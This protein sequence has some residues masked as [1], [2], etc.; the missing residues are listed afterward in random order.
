MGYGYRS[1]RPEWKKD[2]A[3]EAEF[4]AKGVEITLF[5]GD[6]WHYSKFRLTFE[7]LKSWRAGGKFAPD[8]D[9]LRSEYVRQV[10]AKP[11]AADNM[12]HSGPRKWSSS[13]NWL[14]PVPLQDHIM[15]LGEMI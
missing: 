6:I 10:L 5:S 2:W 15:A 14:K 8:V 11:D 1:M 12:P 3:M 13:E 7:D 9:W 4:D